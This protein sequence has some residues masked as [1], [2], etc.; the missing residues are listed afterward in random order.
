M[1]KIVLSGIKPTG[2]L[3]FGNYFGAIDQFI[4]NQSKDYENLYFV[5]DY[6]A[7]TTNPNNK[8]LFNNSIDIVIDYLALGLDPNISNIFIQSDV[9]SH[10][11][12]A[13]ILS[14]VTPINL[15]KRAHAFKDLSDKEINISASIMYYP[16]LMAADI[17]IYNSDIVPV[18]RDQKQHVEIARDIAIKFNNI[19]G[20]YFKLPEPKILDDSS[21]ILGID[22]KKMSKSYNNTI[23]I[24]SDPVLLKKRVFSIVTDSK[25]IDEPKDHKE[26]VIFNILQHFISSNE[27]IEIINKYKTGVSYKELK[28]L[29]FEK[30]LEFQKPIVKKRDN[31]IKNMDYVND[32]ISKGKEKASYI[33][34][35]NMASIRGL[36]GIR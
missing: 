3:H 22:G 33:A 12:L 32:I 5:A 11:E 34:E 14:S 26:C 24:F 23:E 6:H 13:W 17:L 18:G 36:V 35:K 10:C 31:L 16:V 4:K 25:G 30:I 29:L 2:K 15:L 20:N 21:Y 28:N 27:K 9:K 8:V 19:Y 1:K 7:L